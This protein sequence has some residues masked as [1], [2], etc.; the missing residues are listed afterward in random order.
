MTKRSL[1]QQYVMKNGLLFHFPIKEEKLLEKCTR[2]VN[3]L[4][5]KQTVT[6]VLCEKYFKENFVKSEK[7][8]TLNLKLN[9][10]PSIQSSAAMKGGPSSFLIMTGNLL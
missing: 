2:V 1:N 5:W 10:I 6:S 4:D 9:P 3:K 8:T 7:R